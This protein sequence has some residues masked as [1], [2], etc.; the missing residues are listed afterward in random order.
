LSLPTL[1]LPPLFFAAGWQASSWELRLKEELIA[2]AAKLAE[3]QRVR[4]LSDQRLQY[5]SPSAARLDLK[6]EWAAGFPYTLS[7]ASA[8]A[9][10]MAL[11][12]ANPLPK[13]GL[14]TDLDNTLWSGIIGETGAREISWDLDN[15]SQANGLYQ[16]FLKTLSD[17]GVLIGVASK[18][19]PA[20]VDDVLTRSD[21]ILDLNKVFPLDVSWGSKASAVSR[22]LSTWN[23]N[24]DSVVFVDDDS[25]ELAEVQA[26]HPAMTCMQFPRQNPQAAYQ[27]LV[28][29]RDLFGKDKISAEDQIRLESIRA[30]AKFQSMA[31]DADGFSEALLEQAEP[32]LILHSQKETSDSRALELLNK[33]NQFNLN[34]KRFTDVAWQQYLAE[35]DTFMLTATY[36]DRFGQLGKIAVMAGRKNG[37]GLKVES[38]V[39]SCRAFSR[40]IEHQC[41]KF[42]FDSF[43]CDVIEFDYQKTPRN[44][45]LGAFL[46]DLL[47]EMPTS[48]PEISKDLFAAVCPKLFHRVREIK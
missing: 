42:L 40:R 43:N 25:L 17:E 33:T 20:I 26:A 23:I 28:D 13:K 18:N 3:H 4:L 1:P 22:I 34:G 35:D 6:S 38:W 30:G 12:I 41:L 29:L 32:E 5:L 15:H 46:T 36:Q 8:L 9:E 47:N 37:R 14:I 27:L 45:P 48:R 31:T 16:Q 44:G 10:L 19:D 39:M 7:H 21:M 24:A 2:F 11:L